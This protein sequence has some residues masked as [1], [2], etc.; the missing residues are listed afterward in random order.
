M[1]TAWIPLE[2]FSKIYT[3]QIYKGSHNQFHPLN[4]IKKEKTQF[5]EFL[6]ILI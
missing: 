5:Q 4:K 1:I 6:I 3:L 2:G